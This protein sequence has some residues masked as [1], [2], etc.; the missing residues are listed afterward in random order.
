MNNEHLMLALIILGRRHVKRMDVYLQQLIDK[1]KQ[2]WEGIH[3]YNISRSILLER[4][5]MLYG[6]YVYTTNDYLGLEVC[7][8]KHVFFFFL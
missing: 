4:S 7:S 6:I 3:I 8:H 5:F 1:F 2:L